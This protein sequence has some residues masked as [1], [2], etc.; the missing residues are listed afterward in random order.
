MYGMYGFDPRAAAEAARGR[1]PERETTPVKFTE[2]SASTKP[3]EHGRTCFWLRMKFHLNGSCEIHPLGTST[4][5]QVVHRGCGGPA[6]K[7]GGFSAVLF[8]M[9]RVAFVRLCVLDWIEEFMSWDPPSSCVFDRL[10]AV[11][12]LLPRFSARSVTVCQL[13]QPQQC[14]HASKTKLHTKSCAQE[15]LS[16]YCAGSACFGCADALWIR[17]LCPACL[18]GRS[19]RCCCHGQ[20]GLWFCYFR[21][22]Q[23]CHEIP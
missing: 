11:S 6:Y 18:Q 5:G 14:K 13:L 21:R 17:S 4:A 12:V 15:M 23:G 9:V 7:Q 20:E 2:V 3:A 10:T 16:D 1:A 8:S 22:P 19:C